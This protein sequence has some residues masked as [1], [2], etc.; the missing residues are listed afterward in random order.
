MKNLVLALAVTVLGWTDA[1]AQ[2]P[3]PPVKLPRADA[4]FV[5]GWQN[6]HKEQPQD[7]YNDW[8]NDIFYGAA[9]AG[10]YW[11]DN[12]K[13]QVDVGAGSR[14]RQYRTRQFQIDRNVAYESSELSVREAAVTITQQYQ[15]FRNQW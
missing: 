14:G 5:I 1:A 9:G 6:L 3:A 7:H 11:T 12:I 4:Q 8:L 15:F 2:T 13:T 10:W